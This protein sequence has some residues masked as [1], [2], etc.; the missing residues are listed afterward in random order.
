[1]RAVVVER[2][3]AVTVK[4]VPEPAVGNN[5][6]VLRTSSASICNATDNHILL[7]EFAGYHDHY[8]QI[9][10]HEVCGEVVEVGPRVD[11]VAIGERLVTYTPNGAFCEYTTV[12]ADWAWARV[13]EAVPDD[14]AP[15]GEMFHGALIG[16]VYPAGLED[17]E[18]AVVIGA[19]P[20][21][22]VTIQAMKA[23]ASIA[24][25]VVERVGFRCAMAKRLGA[26]FAYD[27]SQMT[28]ADVVAAVTRDMGGPVDLV[29]VCTAVDQSP[30]QDLF[31]LAVD[32][33]RP[34][35]RVTGLNVEVK[36]LDHSVHIL[37]LFKKRVLLSRSLHPDVYGP[38]GQRS[39]HDV[40]QMGLEWVASGAVN[41]EALI[42]HRVGLDDIEEG[43]R[44]CREALDE[45]V[46]VVVDV[47]DRN[48]G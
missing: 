32:L 43:L 21:G 41:L 18:R 13:P 30:E 36:G 3:G 8:P 15:T 16:T 4:E 19:G 40:F 46:K 10:G 12:P 45:T 29:C 2:P 25:G 28:R 26:D 35:G 33:V 38:L 9:L 23:T 17:G 22:L 37:D 39:E 34:E 1:M 6:I 24:V 47:R 14:V 44:L 11:N 31:D 5:D 20:M 48:R 7:G 42:T 27:N